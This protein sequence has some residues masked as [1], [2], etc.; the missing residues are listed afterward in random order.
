M[1]ATRAWRRTGRA[2]TF[3]VRCQYTHEAA[4]FDAIRSRLTGEFC[5]KGVRTPHCAPKMGRKAV[6][7]DGNLGGI[8]V[9]QK[10]NAVAWLIR[11]SLL[12]GFM[13]TY[14]R[15]K[16]PLRT[17]NPIFG[18]PIHAAVG[19]RQRRSD[20]WHQRI[21]SDSNHSR[22]SRTGSQGEKEKKIGNSSFRNSLKNK[23]YC[24]IMIFFIVLILVS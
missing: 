6:Y 20:H 11:G 15:P 22:S 2:L 5:L 17:T 12:V 8:T 13:L 7:I 23:I 1:S 4:C 10:I 19:N 14:S 21:T 24:K 9:T 16:T 18:G 3:S